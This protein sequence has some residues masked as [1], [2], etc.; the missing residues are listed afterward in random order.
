MFSPM[1]CWLHAEFDPMVESHFMH[2]KTNGCRLCCPCTKHLLSLRGSFK[3]SKCSGPA[4]ED[5]P[6]LNHHQNHRISKLVVW[7]S[8]NPAK[9]SVKPF[10]FGGSQLILRAESILSWAKIIA[11]GCSRAVFSNMKV[12][13][14]K[15][16]QPSGSGKHFVDLHNPPF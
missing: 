12:S 16:I 1:N 9:N 4:C 3:Q 10:F 13:E 2:G 5:S 8:Q 14:F 7:S 11:L 6:I 15:N